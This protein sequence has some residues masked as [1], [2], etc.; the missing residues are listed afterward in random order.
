M[1]ERIEYSDIGRKEDRRPRGREDRKQRRSKRR[2]EAGKE[3]ER[4]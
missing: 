1:K 4:E 3:G 2:R